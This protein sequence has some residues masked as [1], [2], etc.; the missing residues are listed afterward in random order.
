MPAAELEPL[1]AIYE[2][3]TP[4]DPV[5]AHSW[6]FDGDPKLPEG[7]TYRDIKARFAQRD[8]ACETAIAAAYESGGEKA[9]LSIAESAPVPRMVGRAFTTG[10]G[11]TPALALVA[12]HVGSDN[13]KLTKM[14]RGALYAIYCQSGWDGLEYALAMLKATNAQPPALAEVFLAPQSSPDTW[15][16]LTE[17]RPEVQRRYWEQFDPFSASQNDEAEIRFVAKH[18][19]EVQRSLA[20]V[21]WIA[22]MPVHHEIVIQTLEQLPADLVADKAQEPGTAGIIHG[23]AKMLEKLDESSAVGD[24]VIARLELPF[25]PHCFPGGTPTSRSIA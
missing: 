24:D 4:A 19:L 2:Q 25:C 16:R 6:L 5:Q 22:C 21:D 23:I 13:R 1:A 14:A 17:E 15:Q 10:V 11:A 12:K 3:L 9:I 7:T 20:V 8:A 18:L